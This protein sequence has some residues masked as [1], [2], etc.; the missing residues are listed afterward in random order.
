MKWLKKVY[1]HLLFV[2]WEHILLFFISSKFTI[3]STNWAISKYVI[4]KHLCG[5]I[6]QW[7][8]SNVEH[9][10]ELR[11]CL[12]NKNI[13]KAIRVCQCNNSPS[14]LLMLLPP[15]DRMIET[16][17]GNN[18]GRGEGE[19][20][21]WRTHN[22]FVNYTHATWS[23]TTLTTICDYHSNHNLWLLIQLIK[24]YCFKLFL[25]SLCIFNIKTCS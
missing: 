24:T 13:N 22:C 15:D 18:T 12:T 19:L 11:I 2:R 3:Y 23:T 1:I 7:W 14:P 9:I 4:R 6:I 16:F 25:A 21:C 5:A 17:C 10:L 20:L 8:F